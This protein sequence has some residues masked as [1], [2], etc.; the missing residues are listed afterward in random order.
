MNI[1]SKIVLL[2]WL[3]IL[4]FCYACKKESKDTGREPEV[5]RQIEE[6]KEEAKL[7]VQATQN[8]LNTIALCKLIEKEA[9]PLALAAAQIK[10]EQE[11]F[12]DDFQKVASKNL[13]SISSTPSVVVQQSII[14]TTPDLQAEKIFN[15]INNNLEEQVQALDTLIETGDW[16]TKN[17]AKAH[18]QSIKNKN[19]IVEQLLEGL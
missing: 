6:D 17:L 10:R 8:S 9:S 18:I 4:L 15:A 14:A 1:K 16:D 13:V 3:S 19:N 7:L 11:T 2:I 12:F 5:L